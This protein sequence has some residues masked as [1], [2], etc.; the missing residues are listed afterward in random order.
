[1]RK[2][3]SKPFIVVLIS[4]LTYWITSTLMALIY[5]QGIT[6]SYVCM[7]GTALFTTLTMFASLIEFSIVRFVRRPLLNSTLLLSTSLLL[8][9]ELL[10]LILT[11]KPS[12]FGLFGEHGYEG[13]SL[14]T[15]M[16]SLTG[17]LVS[18]LLRFLIFKPN[19]QPSQG[20]SNL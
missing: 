1:M 4:I 8:T 20:P 15:S 13:E 19:I 9:F 17:I 6:E 11:Q 10:Y 12:F 14:A 18:S 7:I 3:N 16:S 5:C 2:R